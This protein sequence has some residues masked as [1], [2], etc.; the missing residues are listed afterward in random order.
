[1]I[2][3][4]NKI[5]F[6]LIVFHMNNKLNMFY[7]NIVFQFQLSMFHHMLNHNKLDKVHENM[8][9]NVIKKRN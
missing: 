8:T 7:D 9:K 2:D 3:H 5:H 6:L 1:M 4:E